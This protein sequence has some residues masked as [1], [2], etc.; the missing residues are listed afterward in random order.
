[1]CIAHSSGGFISLDSVW[2]IVYGL[3]IS[4]Y[5]Q[6]STSIL[7][8]MW[9]GPEIGVWRWE[10]VYWTFVAKQLVYL[11]PENFGT[12][13]QDL[14]KE[15][16]YV[17]PDP[18]GGAGII[19]GAIVYLF[20]WPKGCRWYGVYHM[21][22]TIAE[23]IEHGYFAYLNYAHLKDYGKTVRQDIGPLKDTF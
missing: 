20:L 18:V 4:V 22:R 3:L 17:N 8:I 15:Y 6:W 2:D 21:W 11:L 5:P 10:V 23:F 19:A 7:K 14:I 16:Q 1:F 13:V 9:L 12:D